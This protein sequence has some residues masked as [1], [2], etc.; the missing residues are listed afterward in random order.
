MNDESHEEGDVEGDADVDEHSEEDGDTEES[1]VSLPR[2]L[3]IFRRTYLEQ[4]HEAAIQRILMK[5]TAI[6][7]SCLFNFP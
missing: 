5:H 2:H 4:L 1:E 6:F 3:F 7:S